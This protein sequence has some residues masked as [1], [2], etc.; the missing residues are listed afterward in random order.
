M[1]Q[2]LRVLQM[3]FRAAVWK[4]TPNPPVVGFAAVVG[5]AA[6]AMVIDA[7]QQ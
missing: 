1:Q 3:G 4:S 7:M 2:V 5:W 6:L